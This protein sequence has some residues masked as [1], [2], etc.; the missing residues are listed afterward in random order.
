M[1]MLP[2]FLEK[3]NIALE[4]TIYFV[5]LGGPNGHMD[6]AVIRAR[7]VDTTTYGYVTV[8]FG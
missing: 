6:C 8:F 7:G 1:L 2:R 4:Y 5:V 3:E